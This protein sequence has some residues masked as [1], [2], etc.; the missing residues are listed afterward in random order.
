MAKPVNVSVHL[1]GKI[2]TSEQLIRLFVRKCKK[3]RIVQEYRETLVHETKGQKR[4]RKRAQSKARR[5][6]EEDSNKSAPTKDK[7]RR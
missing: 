1:G 6:R 3:E 7:L 2:R 5:K 4:R